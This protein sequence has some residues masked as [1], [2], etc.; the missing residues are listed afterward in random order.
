MM[1]SEEIGPNQR[2]RYFGKY[3]IPLVSAL[4]EL[5][6]DL[7]LTKSWDVAAVGGL[8]TFSSFLQM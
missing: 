6:H 7:T 1:M 4:A 3:D 2:T 8:E 5:E